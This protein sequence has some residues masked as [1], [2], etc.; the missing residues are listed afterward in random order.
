MHLA[1]T[2]LATLFAAGQLL[3]FVQAHV[4]MESPIP[5]RSKFLVPNGPN[6]DFTN[7]APLNP[8]GSNFP[9]KGY[10]NDD[11]PPTATLT[12]G[13]S[14]NL[15]YDFST[16]A[17]TYSRLAGS[18][19]HNGG[20][21]QVSLSYDGGKTWVVIHSIMGGY[22]SD[23]ESYTI[24]VPSDLPAGKRVLLAWSWVNH[25]GNRYI[26]AH[27]QCSQHGNST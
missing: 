22:P 25:T 20:S 12:A 1:T 9:C 2:L 24:P 10:H 11:L 5:F 23:T 14:F 8:D 13:G 16:K 26:S 6:T 17:I 21:C 19:T 3:S 4:E 15:Q 7:T 27:L 18:A